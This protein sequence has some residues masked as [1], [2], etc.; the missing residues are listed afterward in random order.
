MAENQPE[1]VQ[2]LPRGANFKRM[3]RRRKVVF[4][5]GL[6]LGIVVVCVTAILIMLQRLEARNASFQ[7]PMTALERQRLL[8]PDP[9]LDSA[10]KLDGLRYRQQVELKVEGYAPEDERSEREE[11]LSR[12]LI[13]QHEDLHADAHSD[14]R[15][16]AQ[17][18]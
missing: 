4:G 16:A 1:G 8:P 15:P 6:L 13:L 7:P 3:L 5:I 18:P 14:L 9:V 10:P 12:T 2:T 11:P 17:T